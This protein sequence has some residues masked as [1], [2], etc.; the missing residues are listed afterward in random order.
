[1]RWL[2]MLHPFERELLHVAKLT[3]M[4]PALVLVHGVMVAP[5]IRRLP[6]ML[7]LAMDIVTIV[8]PLAVAIL[9]PHWQAMID[10]AVFLLCIACGICSLYSKASQKPAAYDS[11]A[12][13]RSA[14]TNIRASV[15]MIVTVVL[16]VVDCSKFPKTYFKS[17]TYGASLMD[18]GVGCVV[19]SMGFTSGNRYIRNKENVSGVK[20]LSQSLLLLALGVVRL[21]VTRLFHVGVDPTEYGLHWNFFMTLSFLPFTIYAINRMSKS[22]V[23]V[24]FIGV[25]LTVLYQALIQ[26]YSL[27]PWIM[28]L[29][30]QPSKL[31][32][33][34]VI[35]QHGKLS[36]KMCFSYP[37]V[38]KSVP[39]SWYDG[40]NFVM[41][42][43]RSGAISVVG[44]I[45]IALISVSLGAIYTK[46]GVH[47]AVYQILAS[48]LF[49]EAFIS[50]SCLGI[51]P[52]RRQ[53]N[54]PYVCAVLFLFTLNSTLFSLISLV[55]STTP[56]LFEIVS[57]H[58]LFVFLVV[59]VVVGLCN[60]VNPFIIR[61]PQTIHIFWFSTFYI[62]ALVASIVS[63]YGKEVSH[64]GASILK[65][66]RQ[67]VKLGK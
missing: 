27:A 17:G 45:A 46:P 21:I 13:M 55:M 66:V 33:F 61:S 29:P 40:F 23:T 50:L 63:S 64:C 15:S 25:I 52:S 49:I 12:A 42:A 1:M 35:N 62:V 24:G 65:A 56:L 60:Y 20:A 57:A 14:I 16:L 31:P 10:L 32:V 26:V 41:N 22:I 3:V 39:K 38:A 28:T 58:Q 44:F 4:A 59:N 30:K 48:V 37:T 18:A 7:V 6:P 8:V 43:N 51:D 19:A 47:P 54:A 2:S 67:Q 5:Y 11:T 36:L 34:H 9:H 53:A